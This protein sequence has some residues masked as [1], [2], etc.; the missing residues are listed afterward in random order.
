MRQ[1]I[2][3]M[4]VLLVIPISYAMTLQ[5]GQC[6]TDE[7]SNATY[8]AANWTVYNITYHLNWG[9]KE[10]GQLGNCNYNLSCKAHEECEIEDVDYTVAGHFW[11]EHTNG[12]DMCYW[13]FGSRPKTS[14]ECGSP[15]E[16][17]LY[18]Q[19]TCPRNMSDAGQIS[20]LNMSLE[21][22]KEYFDELSSNNVFLFLANK[23]E[24]CDYNLQICFADRG[25][26][27]NK[28]IDCEK[29]ESICLGGINTSEYKWAVC[30]KDLSKCEGGNAGMTALFILIGLGAIA[31]FLWTYIKERTV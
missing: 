5:P 27:T 17:T 18:E 2:F 6:H 13:Q 4:I 21:A 22:C 7:Q 11:N 14:W 28:R 3:L 1:V 26:E 16:T 15:F 12:S 25:T 20:D 24:E 30:N 31:V 10:I 23:R 8:C 9:Q 29:R 19:F